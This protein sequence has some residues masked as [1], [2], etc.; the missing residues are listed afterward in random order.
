MAEK[1]IYLDV[2]AFCRPFDDQSYL[3]IKLE[4]IAVNLI[5]SK[6]KEEFYNLL[7]SSAHIEEIR[8]IE[9]IF[10]KIQL[11]ILIKILGKP[12][13]VNMKKTRKRAEGLVVCGLGVADATHVAFA[14][15]SDAY[16]ISCD[17]KLIKKCL[18][19]NINIWCG[20]PVSFCEK[21]GL[22]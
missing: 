1:N 18:N 22:Q 11:Q 12:V 7:I 2:C 4:T 5:L 8:A 10:E 19:N 13:N 14:E 17:D 6:V 16:F 15:M 21:E 3:R 20:T 9:E